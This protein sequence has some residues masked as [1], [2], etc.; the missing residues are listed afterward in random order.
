MEHDF[1][2]EGRGRHRDSDGTWHRCSGCGHRVHF[3]D[4]WNETQRIIAT[5][6]SF[7]SEAAAVEWGEGR[8]R[9]EASG[10][11]PDAYGYHGLLAK[12]CAEARRLSAEAVMRS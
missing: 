2:P 3:G 1:R 6:M 11:E 8:A 12:D 4:G 9:V 5:I 7:A 10:H